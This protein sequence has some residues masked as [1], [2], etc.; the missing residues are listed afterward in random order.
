MK[1]TKMKYKNTL[2]ST[3]VL[4]KLER[5]LKDKFKKAGFNTEVTLGDT[6]H[7]MK[8]GLRMKCFTII[9]SVCGYNADVGY[10]GST[11]SK[12]Y[13]KTCLPTWSQREEFNHIVNDCFDACKMSAK[14]VS[15]SFD[16]RTLDGRVN[17]WSPMNAY[18]GGDRLFEIQPL[19]EV[20]EEV[21]FRITTASNAKERN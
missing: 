9:P 20:E 12:G 13:K 11:T 6:R 3:D 18:N 15:G 7:N 8:I 21:N 5:M 1:V 2:P 14:I 17:E 19:D 16:I 10:H 4:L